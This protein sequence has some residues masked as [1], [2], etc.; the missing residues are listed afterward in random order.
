MNEN[1]KYPAIEG[2]RVLVPLTILLN[3]WSDGMYDRL[4]PQGQ[5]AIDYFF[6]TEGFL[7][8]AAFAQT[9]ITP[10]AYFRRK[11]LT[12]Y[13]IYCLALLAGAWLIW[14]FPSASHF[15]WTPTSIVHA[16]VPN[17]IL[18]PA[19]DA[20]SPLVTP[21]NWPTWA[22]LCELYVLCLYAAGHRLLTDWRRIAA[23]SALCAAAYCLMAIS[24]K[25][26]NLGYL[27]ENYWAGLPRC[28]FGFCVGMLL[29]SFSQR[30]TMLKIPAV[31]VWAI[32][33]GFLFLTVKYIGLFL[34][35]FGT[36][37]I[38]LMAAR[39]TAPAWLARISISLGRL[40]LWIYL[41]HF[42]ILIASHVISAEMG[43]DPE[44]LSS[45]FYY[46]A[47]VAVTLIAAALIERVRHLHW[48]FRRRL[49]TD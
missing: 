3:H 32:A 41:V 21:F 40:S 9:K 33:L 23:L 16:L 43:V 45:P 19:M 1:S 29:Y 28:V 22:I 14:S 37:L 6:A 47:L 42:P 35:L 12:V 4:V 27:A 11:L 15:V 39:A 7:A 2:L 44:R 36:P 10:L 24:A 5:L 48:P 20:P 49:A 31:V 18:L 26:A 25:S 38:M 8:A 13:P 17:L 30:P 46:L 34:F